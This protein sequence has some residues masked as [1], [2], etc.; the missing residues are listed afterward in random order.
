MFV[1]NLAVS[2]EPGVASLVVVQDRKTWSG[3][4]VKGGKC[5]H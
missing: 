2:K 5:L 3:G 4:A 1:L